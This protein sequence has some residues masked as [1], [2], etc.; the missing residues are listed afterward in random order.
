MRLLYLVV[1]STLF[2]FQPL[3]AAQDWP[4]FLGPNADA[5]ST[6]SVPTEWDAKKNMTWKF[7]LP[8]AG[9]S[10]P[11]IIGD[12]VFVT[13]FDSQSGSVVRHVVCVNKKDGTKIWSK[14][15]KADYQEDGFNGYLREHGYASN[16]P[17]SDGESLFVFLGK[18]GVYAFDLDGNQ[19]W[20]K[21]VGKQSSNRRWGSAASLLLVENKVIVNAAEEARAVIAFDKSTGEETWRADSDMLEL[22]FGTPRI[23]TSEGGDSQIVLSVPG[24]VW[25]LKPETGKLRWYVTTPL[26]GNVSPSIVVKDNLIYSLGGYRSKGSVAINVDGKGGAKDLSDSNKLWTSQSTSYVAT[27]LLHEDVFYWIDDRGLANASSATDGTEIYRQRVK[28]LTGRPVYASPVLIGEHIYVVTRNAGTIVYPPGKAFEPIA[29]N[30]IEGDTTDFNA[31]PAV[32]DN[33]LFLRS[34]QALYCIGE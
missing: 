5:K 2:C 22:A 18:G 29:R 33:R 34:D 24:E 13:C 20:H 25:S 19:K 31:S 27:P 3:V 26:T 15:I 7:D 28:G 12:R 32:S 4:Q 11:I 6:D 23:V 16:T 14:E 30:V 17:V 10:S 21:E 1:V 8:G 9:S